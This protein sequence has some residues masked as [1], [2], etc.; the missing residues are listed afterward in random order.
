MLPGIARIG[1]A[2]GGLFVVAD[3]Q[4]LGPHYN[5]TLMAWNGNSQRVWAR[6][7]ER[8]DR[9]FRRMGGVLSPPVLL[10]DPR[11]GFACGDVRRVAAAIA[12]EPAIQAALQE[13]GDRRIDAGG[14]Q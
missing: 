6:L 2:A 7:E 10:R 3:R 1:R 4:N 13:R 5:R 9:R 12:A 11:E 8:C 14:L